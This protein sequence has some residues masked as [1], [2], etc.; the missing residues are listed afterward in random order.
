MK[1]QSG[2]A[3]VRQVQTARTTLR[4]KKDK[5]EQSGIQLCLNLFFTYKR[6]TALTKA[7]QISVVFKQLEKVHASCNSV[8]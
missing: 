1:R 4:I 6:S 3:S 2:E 8:G 5:Q 7:G